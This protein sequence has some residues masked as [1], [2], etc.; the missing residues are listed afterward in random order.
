MGKGSRE[1]TQPLWKETQIVLGDWLAVRPDATADYLFLN[2]RGKGMSRHGF[3]RRLDLHVDVARSR[4]PSLAGKRVS[5]HVLRHSCAIH[6]LEATK[7]DIRKVSLW[8]GHASLQTT[9]IYLRTDPIIKLEM[10]SDMAPPNVRRGKFGNASDA[11]MVML[12]DLKKVQFYGELLEPRIQSC[13]G[14]LRST[15]P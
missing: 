13:Q 15:S 5:P 9:E 8:L 3:A 2:A 4:V 1:R 11:L 14:F 10:L 12:G 6:T 7:G